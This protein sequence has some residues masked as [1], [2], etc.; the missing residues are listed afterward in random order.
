MKALVATVLVLV[1]GA[2]AHRH[3]APRAEMS[4][5]L[6]DYALLHEGGPNDLALVYRAP[7][8]NWPPYDKVLVEPL[9]LWR[10]GRKSLEP[11]PR[12][13][14]LRLVSEFQSAV[15]T[16]LGGSFRLVDQAG[17]GVIRI[18]LA[19]TDAYASDP[20]LDVLTAKRGT[21]RPHAAGDGPLHPETRRFLASAKIEGEIR[22]AQTNALLAE[23]VD[24]HRRDAP[25]LE[26]WAEVDRAFAV[27]AERA[28]ARLETRTGGA[29]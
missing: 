27:W 28:C 3:A 20:V 24:R 22:D 6:D 25:P 13:D 11:V 8:A 16:A 29:R 5:F 17:P 18:R 19:I 2:C 10:S 23:R 14:L 1:A 7:D 4:G 15:L 21:G 12:E 26:T 9:T